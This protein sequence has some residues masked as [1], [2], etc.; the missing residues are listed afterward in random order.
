MRILAMSDIK[1][2]QQECKMPQHEIVYFLKVAGSYVM[3]LILI[4]TVY[5]TP[6]LLIYPE[7]N[8]GSI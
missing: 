7:G 2:T 8:V 1:F 5:F 4:I 6:S 3:W